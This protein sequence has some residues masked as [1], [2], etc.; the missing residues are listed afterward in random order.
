MH[1]AQWASREFPVGQDEKMQRRA[2]FLFEFLEL[3]ADKLAVRE[4]LGAPLPRHDNKKI[5]VPVLGAPEEGSEAP[6]GP[7]KRKPLTDRLGSR[8]YLFYDSPRIHLDAAPHSSR[9][10]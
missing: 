8:P 10:C 6:H 7:D 3:N 9:W 4:K 2:N 5:D 1:V